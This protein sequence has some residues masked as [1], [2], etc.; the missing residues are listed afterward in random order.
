MFS[1]RDFLRIS[2]MASAAALVNWQFPVGAGAQGEVAGEGEYDVIVIGAGLGGLSCASLLAMNGLKPLVI[3]KQDVPGGY[4]SSFQR[5]IGFPF[6]GLISPV[7]K[8]D[9]FACEASLHGITGNPMGQ[10]LLQQLGVL[11]KLILVPHTYSWNSIYPDFP[12]SFPQPPL[13]TLQYILQSLM[14]AFQMEEG[15]EKA[16]KLS[17]LLSQLDGYLHNVFVESDGSS[18]YSALISSFPEE[19]GLAGYMECWK[20]LLADILKFYV[21]DQGIPDDLTQFPIEYPKWADLLWKKRKPKA[22]TLDDLFKEYKIKNPQLKA[23]LGQS[24]FYS[25]LPSSEI[26]AWFY[27]MTT[28]L[29]HAFGNFYLRGNSENNLENLNFQGTSQDLSNLLAANITQPSTSPEVSFPGGKVLL[30]TEV[31]EIIIEDGRAVGVKTTHADDG[32]VEYR[33]KAVVSNASVPQTFGQLLSASAVP[34]DFTKSISRYK[35]SISHFNVWLGIDLTQDDD[36]GFMEAYEKLA[37]HTVC[38]PSYD[39]DRMFSGLQKCDPEKTV[40]A[41]VAYD[42]LPPYDE[43][44]LGSKSVRSPEG[45]ASIT[46]TML[47][48]YDPWEKF[49]EVYRNQY[50]GQGDTVSG[51]VTFD[52]YRDEKKRITE[53]LIRIAETVLPGLSERIVMHEASTPL[54]NVR[55]TYNPG[56]AIYGYEQSLDNSGLSRLENRTPIPGLYLSSAWTNPG[57]SFELVMLSGKEAVKCMVEDGVF[58]TS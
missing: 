20:E 53:T 44:P 48:G 38:Y 6:E 52:D 28:G 2:A 49:E 43:L 18:M 40:V 34:L 11:D 37:S 10:V 8:D 25:G 5:Q 1:R 4:A 47:S 56:G 12:V 3:E 51:K 9:F 17:D 15:E 27:L 45:C 16:E 46:L 23:I 39:H 50:A 36:D 22:K 58:S 33:A 21:T 41:V 42:K 14:E 55:F 13:D 32:E 30:N 35:P 7:T 26:P 19:E 24:W 31:T 57:G 29:Y 54:T